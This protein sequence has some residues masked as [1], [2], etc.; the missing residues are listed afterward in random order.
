[1]M[2]FTRISR[3]ILISALGLSMA[4]CVSTK[5]FKASEAAR[6]DCEDKKKALETKVATLEHDTTECGMN[7]RGLM[8]DKDFLEQKAKSEK[9]HL[10]Q[11]LGQK[12]QELSEKEKLLLDREKKMAE[13]QAIIDRKDQVLNELKRKV[14]DALVGFKGDE[15]T[16]QMKNGKLYVSL[17]EKLLFASGS[18][19]VDPKGKEAITK[20]AAVLEKNQ[21]ID[22]EIEGHT[23]N[24]KLM[25]GKFDD[26]WDLSVSRATSI[27]RILTQENKIDP[28]RVTA[29]GR[30]E[31]L[32]VA[33]NSTPEGRAKNRRTEIILTPKLDELFKMLETH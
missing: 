13:L 5:K 23:D 18:A 3:A 10:S 28:K 6:M 21:D 19:T 32:P 12:G 11:E 2:N 24:V 8:A 20:L 22:V 15:L 30:G 9:Q 31:Y 27:V 14:S 17:S 4:S 25:P 16:V 29:S 26:N 33:D 1:M 7:Y